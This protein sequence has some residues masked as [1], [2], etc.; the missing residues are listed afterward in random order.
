[1]KSS[2]NQGAYFDEYDD[3]EPLE[4]VRSSEKKKRNGGNS[5][6]NF[7]TAE[8]SN[9]KCAQRNEENEFTDQELK[10]IHQQSSGGMNKRQKLN[11][12]SSNSKI[13]SG[14]RQ[15]NF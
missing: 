8:Y 9:P 15:F 10:V 14:N 5:D 11:N 7:Y 4:I 12:E 13:F 3:R 1:M 6:K 2:K